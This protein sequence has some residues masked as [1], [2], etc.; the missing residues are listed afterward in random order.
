MWKIYIVRKFT[1]N[2][3]A[4][5]LPNIYF[6]NKDILVIPEIWNSLQKFVFI[7]FW[8]HFCGFFWLCCLPLLRYSLPFA[9]KLGT[10]QIL[11]IYLKVKV[12][13]SDG[14]VNLFLYD[15][16]E[17]KSLR[18]AWGK[19]KQIMILKDF[20]HVHFNKNWHNASCW[21]TLHYVGVKIKILDSR[22]V[23]TF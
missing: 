15:I 23:K 8:G 21:D 2:F 13:I 18:E 3:R 11:I 14:C 17:S 16:L 19:K 10:F 1:P 5:F 22:L 7:P 6:Q 9:P 4:F 20:A 12:T